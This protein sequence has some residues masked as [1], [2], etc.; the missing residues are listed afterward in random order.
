MSAP[1]NKPQKFAGTC[2]LP[3]FAADPALPPCEPPPHA[4]VTTAAASTA[5]HTNVVF[6]FIAYLFNRAARMR[7]ELSR[8]IRA[9]PSEQREL[10]PRARRV[11]EL[12]DTGAADHS[13]DGIHELR[14]GDHGHT[15]L[16]SQVALAVRRTGFVADHE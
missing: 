1:L 14:V 16:A 15:Q 10:I 13:R 8:A 7:A 9:G 5:A 2:T 3:P 4:A 6:A 11:D 12:L